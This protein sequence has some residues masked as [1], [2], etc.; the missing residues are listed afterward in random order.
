MAGPWFA[1]VTNNSDWQQLDAIW[2]SDGT[3]D[4]RGRVE[5][6]IEMENGND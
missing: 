1:V 2:I 5:I 6:R 3:T 4:C